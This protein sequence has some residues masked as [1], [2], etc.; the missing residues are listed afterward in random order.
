MT[1]GFIMSR[2]PVPKRFVCI[3]MNCGSGMNGGVRGS[4]ILIA[5]AAKKHRVLLEAHYIDK[6]PRAIR[7]LRREPEFAQGHLFTNPVRAYFHRQNNAAALP[8]IAMTL[9]VSRR[10]VIVCDPNGCSGDDIPIAEVAEFLRKQH[11]F[12]LFIHLAGME[13]VAGY[14]RKDE[15]EKAKYDRKGT[16]YSVSRLRETIPMPLQVVH[17]H[18]DGKTQP[19]FIG[20]FSWQWIPPHTDSRLFRVDSHEGRQILRYYE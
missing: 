1:F 20:I 9:D 5:R 7:E 18:A 6:S 12:T 14:A 13:R 19:H 15:S 4:P 17:R 3:D 10:G 11:L 8:K 2:L 16:V